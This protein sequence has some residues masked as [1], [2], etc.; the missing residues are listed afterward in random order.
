MSATLH[1]T[2]GD[3]K[4]DLH[5]HKC[6]VS[7]FNFLALSAS[8]YYDQCP[9]HRIIAGSLVQMGDPTGTGRHGSSIYRHLKN[10]N[11]PS[12]QPSTDN[13]SDSNKKKKNEERGYFRDELDPELRHDAR[14]T[15]SMA[16]NGP[17]KNASQFYITLSPHPQP[18]LDDKFTVFGRVVDGWDVLQRFNELEVSEFRPVRECLIQK[19][20]VHSNPF[21]DRLSHFDPL[22]DSII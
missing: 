11:Q 13:N 6:P 2:I 8:G 16:N 9:I 12:N 19:V 4:L 15:L 20:T 7:A 17:N 1:T 5:W 10:S 14:G 22:T 3:I 18:Q 21:A